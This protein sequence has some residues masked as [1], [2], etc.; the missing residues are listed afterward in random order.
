MTSLH[1]LCRGM[2]KI[3]KKIGG[4]VKIP[5][6]IFE[7]ICYRFKKLVDACS[8][9]GYVT[10][11]YEDFHFSSRSHSWYPG[12][13]RKWR[14]EKRHCRHEQITVRNKTVSVNREDMSMMEPKTFWCCILINMPV[15]FTRYLQNYSKVQ[16]RSSPWKTGH[17]WWQ[18]TT[19]YEL[20]INLKSL[21][22]IL[23]WFLWNRTTLNY[24]P[25]HKCWPK[26]SWTGNQGNHQN[27]GPSLLPKN[28]WLLFMGL[29]KSIVLVG[30]Y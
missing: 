6:W 26:T 28:L 29:I 24:S 3:W 1:L 2:F 11:N 22:Q 21:D 16:N 30:L 17:L 12:A 4:Y 27:F 20:M 23:E 25:V 9:Q 10:V 18:N 5:Q 19:V 13:K 7:V 8:E 15:R 14:R